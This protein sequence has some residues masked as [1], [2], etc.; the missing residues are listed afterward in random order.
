MG[1]FAVWTGSGGGLIR[2][3][4]YGAMSSVEQ[5]NRFRWDVGSEI[6]KGRRVQLGEC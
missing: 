4:S 3:E 2:S 1:G 6:L 5:R